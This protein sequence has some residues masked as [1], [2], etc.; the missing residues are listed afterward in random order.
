MKTLQESDFVTA[1]NL[2]GC[3]VASVKAVKEVESRGNGFQA[4]G[5]PVILFERHK[6]HT[7]TKGKY[8][9]SHPNISNSKPGGYGAS[10]TQHARLQEAV[11]LD[12]DSALMSASWGL[13]Q[14]MGFNWK[15]LGYKDLQQFITAMYSSETEQL[16]AFV[17]FVK[18]N[19]LADE[20]KRKDW[21]GFARG[22]NGSNYKIN[23]YDVKL[24]N[25]YKKFSK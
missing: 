10:S 21:A 8:D 20:L 6:F 17:R 22:Y 19:G 3:E 13:F 18:A 7:F 24:A 15:D 11:K 23:N 2:L 25:A 1:A 4:D 14:V 16:M 12:R 5:Q 9:K